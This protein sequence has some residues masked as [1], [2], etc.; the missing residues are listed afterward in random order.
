MSPTA[1][2]RESIEGL[3][4]GPRDVVGQLP[5]LRTVLE[6]TAG[7]W[8]EEISQISATAPETAFI[9]VESGP[10]ESMIA[11][12]AGQKSACILEAQQWNARLILCTDQD[13]ISSVVEM[14]LGGDGSE[15]P[16]PADR[17]ITRTDL[18]VVQLVFERFA[19]AL[20]AAFDVVAPTKFLVGK[21]GSQVAFDVLGR[22][23]VPI[24]A[25]KYRLSVLGMSG[26]L[27]LLLSQSVLSPMRNQLSRAAPPESIMPDPAWSQKIH[28]E[29]TRA[30]VE[31][32]AVLDEEKFLLEDVARFAVGQMLQL[33]ATPDSL[34][35]VECNGERLINCNIGKS[36][37]VY[38]LRIHDFID[39]E[40]EFMDDILAG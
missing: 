1:A 27:T 39:Q 2:P 10:S 25:V 20:E 13:F 36:K 12:M 16:P 19:R 15:P 11:A 29:V 9:G 23:T 24:V 38:A 6:K 34:V 3:F 17:S 32:V 8:V 18:R 21:A 31:L 5:M 4:A 28:S 35:R 33:R 14:L 22:L 37:G 7:Y 40:Q 26:E 30:N